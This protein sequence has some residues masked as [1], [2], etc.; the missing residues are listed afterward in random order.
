MKSITSLLSNNYFIATL[1]LL[2]L[3]FGF[4]SLQTF[5][6][7][8]FLNLSKVNVEILLSINLILLIFLCISIVFKIKIN[9]SKKKYEELGEE[10]SK[11]LIRSFIIISSLPSA[12]IVIFSLII[13]KYGIQNWFDDKILSLVNNSRNIAVNYLNDHQ[14]G[15]IKDINL[16]AYDLNRNKNILNTNKKKFNEYLNFQA[17]FRDIQ[18][19][20]IVDQSG[21][22]QIANSQSEAFLKPSADLL[23]QASNGKPLIISNANDKKT[24]AL[25][26]LN[27][28]KNFY[29]YSFQ[30]VDEKI[31]SFLKE[32][33]NASTY[34]YQVKSNIFKIQITFFMIYIV[35]TLL[36]LMLSALFGINM[37][38]KTTRPLNS[39]FRAAK[40]ISQDNYDISLPN[41]SNKD[42]N[43]LNI[44]FNSMVDQIKKQKQKNIL[45]GR[46]E[47]WQVI[48]RKLAHEIRNPLTP[49]QLSLD[50]LKNKIDN[51]ENSKKHF[52]IINNQI[53]EISKLVNSFS[54]F[55]RM[56]K[57][58]LKKNN[59]KDILVKSLDVYKLNYD[60]IKFLLKINCTNFVIECDESQINRLLL[61]VY[62]NAVESIEEQFNEDIKNGEIITNLSE[63]NDY[64]IITILDNG[65]GFD[66]NPKLKHDDPY[67]TTKKN[68]SGLGLSIVSKIVH[69]HNGHVFYENR[70]DSNGALV[71]ISLKKK[72]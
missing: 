32:T 14:K 36:L 39:L 59:I 43:N 57:P 9:Y 53:L 49:I 25:I 41:E 62:K 51:N 16:I 38:S 68:G 28:Y 19:I 71:Y 8:G 44:I 47:A 56:P 70:K 50:R 55:A 2:S 3:I 37:A 24:Y 1:F 45:S 42:F 21:S 66:E 52:S 15:I 65:I 22:L 63:D 13:F 5:I 35:F 27:N 12:L 72:L 18:N 31:N 60:R 6:G 61:N 30:N 7:T 46:Y 4:I 23:K 67:F 64:Y 69:E 58:V 33:G 10:T 11:N 29:L 48:A 54:N 26:K 20:F 17:Q 34:Y 40:N